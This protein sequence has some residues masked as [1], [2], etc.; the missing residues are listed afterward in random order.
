MV[1]GIDPKRFKLVSFKDC[2]L[3]D[4]V[5]TD[6]LLTARESLIIGTYNLQNIRIPLRNYTTS[7][8]DFLMKLA[9]RNVKILICLAPFMQNSRFMQAL[10]RDSVAK[11][12]I[13]VRFCRRMHFKTIIVDLKYAYMGT[14][15]LSGAGVGLKSEKRRNFELGFVTEDPDLIADITATFLEIF[16][17]KFCSK[18]K[19]HFFE[20][21]YVQDPCRGIFTQSF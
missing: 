5:I 6:G 11:D 20:N 19:C 15:N 17:G 14:A 16:N 10:S 13:A 2:E 18:E 21:Y 8:S 3:F 12:K 9:K 1:V 7:L 4:K